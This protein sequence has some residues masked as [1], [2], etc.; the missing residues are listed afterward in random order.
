MGRDGE[1]MSFM[2]LMGEAVKFHKPGENYKTDGYVI[3]EKTMHLMKQH[4]KTTGGKVGFFKVLIMF[5]FINI[6]SINEYQ[7]LA[8]I[9]FSKC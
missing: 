9:N 8:V 5:F 4:L 7:S 3:T 6:L 1:V 2:E